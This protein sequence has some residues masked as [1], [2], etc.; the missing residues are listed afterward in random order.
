ML[1]NPRPRKSSPQTSPIFR[2]DTKQSEAWLRRYMEPLNCDTRRA[3]VARAAGLNPADAIIPENHC[4]RAC[5]ATTWVQYAT[6]MFGT[7]GANWVVP[8]AM[9]KDCWPPCP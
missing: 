8:A 6:G 5:C 4:G 7:F 3:A 9:D 2:A 1:L